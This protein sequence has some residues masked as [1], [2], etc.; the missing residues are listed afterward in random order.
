MCARRTARVALLLLL[1][2]WQVCSGGT[3]GRQILSNGDFE[4]GLEGWAGLW[5]REEG[6]GTAALDGRL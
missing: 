1:L 6:A 4:R 3:G 2:G 5:V